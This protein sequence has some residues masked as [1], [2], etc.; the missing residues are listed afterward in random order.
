MELRLSGWRGVSLPAGPSPPSHPFLCYIS[1][2]Y[3]SG[4]AASFPFESRG[5]ARAI[6]PGSASSLGQGW[7]VRSQCG[8]PSLPFPCQAGLLLACDSGGLHACLFDGQTVC[9][10]S[11][12]GPGQLG[13]AI[14]RWVSMFSRT[15]RHA[16]GGK[17]R[18]LEKY[19]ED[20]RGHGYSILLWKEQSRA[21]AAFLPL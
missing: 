13:G 8:D 5:Q 10:S 20:G 14:K 9:Q 11:E 2:N 3:S 12:S 16:G 1:S 19:G 6:T 17:S 7:L 4:W 15:P 18:H 21:Q